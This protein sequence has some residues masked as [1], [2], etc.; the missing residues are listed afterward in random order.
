MKKPKF[1][2]LLIIGII[3]AICLLTYHL[4]KKGEI[5]FFSNKSG[6]E[7]SVSNEIPFLK[8]EYKLSFEEPISLKIVN[9]AKFEENEKWEGDSGFDFDNFIEGD[10]SLYLNSQNQQQAYAALVLEEQIDISEFNQISIFINIKTDAENVEELSLSLENEGEESVVLPIEKLKSGWNLWTFS[11]AKVFFPNTDKKEIKKIKLLLK[12]RANTISSLNFDLLRL[13]KGKNETDL[14]NAKN[15]TAL[16]YSK[17]N[18]KDLPLI[19]SDFNQVITLKEVTSVKNFTFKAKITPIRTGSFGLVIRGDYSTG[20]GYYF[21]LNG[22]SNN[23]WQFFVRNDKLIEL[24][25]GEIR[26][27]M[28]QKNES[29]WLK[30]RA[31]GSTNVLYFSIDGKN[32][33]KIVSVVDKTYSSGGVGF[34]GF[35]GAVFL[36][37]EI[38]LTQ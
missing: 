12:S 31:S 34:C 21:I 15:P 24:K 14:F 11:T 5:K 27:F 35:G 9:L 20:K 16:I 19:I 36:V 22:I 7:A 26:N 18:S 1:E 32:F 17:P 29:I 6:Y 23:F 37:D 8:K 10:S 25:R 3:I 4:Y 2:T 28:F 13:V 38:E 33:I 30:V